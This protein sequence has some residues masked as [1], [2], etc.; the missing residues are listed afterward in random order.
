[1]E[2]DKALKY[3]GPENFRKYLQNEINDIE[4]LRRA[5]DF[6]LQGN[7][8]E[9]GFILSDIV[10]RVGELLGFEVQYG[11]YWQEPN[12][13]WRS[14][15]E[16]RSLIVKIETVDDE[17]SIE[18]LL[19]YTGDSG[20]SLILYVLKR[21]NQN[22]YELKHISKNG[23]CQGKVRIIS[24]DALFELLDLK[25]K[26][27]MDCREVLTFFPVDFSDAGELIIKLKELFFKKKEPGYDVL[28][29]VIPN[30]TL[31]E[32]KVDEVVKIDLDQFEK[33]EIL[34]LSQKRKKKLEL[35]K[36]AKII[37]AYIGQEKASNWKKLVEKAARCVVKTGKKKELLRIKPEEY[38]NCFNDG[39][40]EGTGWTYYPEIDLS[41]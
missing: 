6:I 34:N 3:M 21:S 26:I 37:E 38:G 1:M 2:P 25:K 24:I 20:L 14:P 23:R 4:Y 32:E 39:K 41:I 5:K 33:P 16:D 31:V 28:P 36:Y 27:D 13:I 11:E 15:G 35:L 12:G 18:T 7:E 8:K 29:K 40:R 17:L 19:R 9:Y 10:N 22:L 30:S